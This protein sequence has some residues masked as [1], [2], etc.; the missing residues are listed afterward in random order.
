M[1][2]ILLKIQGVVS[3]M[4][5]ANNAR[6]IL[7]VVSAATNAG[8]NDFGKIDGV[9]YDFKQQHVPVYVGSDFNYGGLPIASAGKCCS[10]SY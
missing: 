7:N 5:A 10:P 6:I 1:P 9:V 4:E 2:C 3:S 8:K